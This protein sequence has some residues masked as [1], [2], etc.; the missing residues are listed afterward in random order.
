MK[1]VLISLFLILSIIS[2][3]KESA[4]TENSN[5]ETELAQPLPV[6]TKLTESKKLTSENFSG[7]A[8]EAKVPLEFMAKPS[9]GSGEDL[10]QY[11]SYFFTSA[12]SLVQFYAY[13]TTGNKRPND[14]IFPNERIEKETTQVGDTLITTWKLNLNQQIGYIREFKEKAYPNGSIITGFYYKTPEAYEQYKDDFQQFEK[15]LKAKN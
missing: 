8:F 12:D 1:K 15:S 2:C 4:N 14:I 6:E 11:D 10:N 7:A 9:V 5:S 3:T 13:A